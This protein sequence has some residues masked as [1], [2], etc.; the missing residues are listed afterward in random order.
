MKRLTRI[1]VWQLVFFFSLSAFAQTANSPLM[2]PMQQA[3]SKLK[4]VQVT[5]DPDYDYVFRMRLL[6]QGALE[7]AK[8]E[9]QQGADPAAKQKAQAFVDAKQKE[10][11]DLEAL[12]RQMRPSRPNQAYVQQQSRQIEAIV[13]KMQ[14]DGVAAKLTGKLDE[15]FNTLLT[16]Y[17]RDASDLS[18]AYLS[19]GNNASVKAVAQKM[20]A[21]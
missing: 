10:L 14:P 6:S 19:F 17:N 12:Q 7:M 13:L 2:A 5:G 3:A 21:Q 11:A 1:A 4:S 8:V 18:R 16:E 15:D 20:V 9:A